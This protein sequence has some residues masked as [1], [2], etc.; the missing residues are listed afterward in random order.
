MEEKIK[1]QTWNAACHDLAK[2]IA[3]LV[4][5][6]QMDYG[7]SNIL[8]F[9]EFGILVRTNDKVARLKNLNGKDTPKN[10]SLDDTWKDV[11]GYALLALMLRKGYFSLP[12][13][14]EKEGIQHGKTP[15]NPAKRF[16]GKGTG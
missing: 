4:I 10:E 9:G 14:G 1:Y 3:D 6:K 11:M 2:E 13:E 15:E 12:L 7:R 8:D 16:G 5:S